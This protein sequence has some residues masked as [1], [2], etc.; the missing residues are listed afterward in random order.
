MKDSEVKIIEAALAWRNR[1]PDTTDW[2]CANTCDC[3][4]CNLIRACDE[5]NQDK[6]I[7]NIGG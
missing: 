1:Q 4:V 7:K 3:E 2:I 5:Y 6:T